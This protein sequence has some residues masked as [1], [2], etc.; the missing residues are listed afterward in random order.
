MTEV[1]YLG[2]VV[3]PDSMRM[4]PTKVDTV[5]NWPPLRN[6]KE[7]QSF[8]G[9]ANFYCCFINNYSGITKPLNRLTRKDTPW[10]WDSKCQ[11]VFLLL[12]RAFTSAPVLRHF[13]PSLL[14]VLEC[15]ASNYAITGILSQSDLGGKDLCSIAFYTQS[16]IPAE[17]N[18]NI[19]DKELLA[20]VKAF[21][22]WWAYLEGS[23]HCIQVYSDHNNPQYFMTTKQLSRRQA[24]WSKT[25][26]EY[27]FTIHYCPG[28]LVIRSQMECIQP[29]SGNPP[30]H[31]HAVLILNEEGILQ[32][33]RNLPPDSFF[34]QHD[35]RNN[36]EE[37]SAGNPFSLSP[38]HRLLLQS[39]RIYALDH[40]S[41][42][43]N[44]LQQHHDHKLRGHPGIRMKKD[45]MQY[46]RACEPCLWAKVPRHCP[47]GLL[48]P[49]LIGRRPWSS[50]LMDH[51]VKLPDSKGFTV[52]LVVVC[53][54]TKQALF[55]PCH[56]TDNALEFA[57]LF[58]EHVF[59]K[60]RL[61]DDII[62]DCR[63]LFVSHFW[64]SLC[65]ALEIKTNLSTAYHP[66][67]DRQTERVNQMLEQY[68]RLYINY[69]Q[70]DWHAELPLAEFTYNNTPHSATR[71]SP[72]YANK[73]YN[74]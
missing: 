15:N 6:V 10:D 21:R 22:Q 40:K 64:Q 54:L 53:C 12:K 47:H 30:K 13:D 58:L 57:K 70:N 42:R 60:H 19:Y 43:L 31:L 51:I 65:R 59:S 2:V 25:L 68:L 1:E 18:Y 56:T 27:N 55:I 41:I 37:L 11:S 35:P 7:V 46:V 44:I 74:S 63:P 72:F 48:K 5:L 26:S 34:T 67:T 28:Q 17:L 14:I 52:I 9:F 71:V 66:E 29:S 49:L 33:I 73:G 8:L 16:M 4:D 62:S 38:D 20:I 32:Q 50:L 3:T 36:P 45:A 39:G 23:L 69:L 61:P 24:Q